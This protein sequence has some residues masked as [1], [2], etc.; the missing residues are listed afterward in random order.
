MEKELHSC[1]KPWDFWLP[2]QRHCRGQLEAQQHRGGR[3]VAV[4]MKYDY[5]HQRDKVGMLEQNSV[6]WDEPW[7]SAEGP[8]KFKE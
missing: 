1:S 7:A 6:F 4:T 8:A 3:E 5:C 2:E